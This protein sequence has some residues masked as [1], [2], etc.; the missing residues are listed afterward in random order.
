[1]IR[2]SLAWS[3]LAWVRTRVALATS[4]ALPFLLATLL[5][6]RLGEYLKTLRCLATYVFAIWRSRQSWTRTDLRALRSEMG[7][8]DFLCCSLLLLLLLSF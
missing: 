3:G 7:V 4:L 6:L 1:M 2:R 5:A 8:V